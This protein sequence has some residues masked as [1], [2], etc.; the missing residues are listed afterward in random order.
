MSDRTTLKP[1]SL[2]KKFPGNAASFF[3]VSNSFNDAVMNFPIDRIPPRLVLLPLQ[4]DSQTR[5]K[6]KE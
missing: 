3:L 2:S 1:V 6:N 4:P 5:A